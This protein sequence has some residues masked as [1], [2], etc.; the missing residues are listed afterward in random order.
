MMICEIASVNATQLVEA[1]M[2]GCETTTLLRSH[3]SIAISPIDFTHY[4]LFNIYRAVPFLTLWLPSRD[5][6]IRELPFWTLLFLL[7]LGAV[8][9][10]AAPIMT[11][12]SFGMAQ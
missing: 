4:N 5:S 10:V 1:A 9:D 7:A 3:H 2:I 8:L 11:N 12:V 6:P